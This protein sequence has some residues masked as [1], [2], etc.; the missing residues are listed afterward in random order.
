MDEVIE[1]VVRVDEV[2]SDDTVFIE[3]LDKHDGVLQRQRFTAL[4]LTLGTAYRSDFI[5]D[6]VDDAGASHV[7]LRLERAEDG[8]LELVAAEGSTKFWAPGGMTRRWRVDA[9]QAASI[10]GARL[11]IRTPAYAPATDAKRRA[12]MSHLNLGR[13]AWVWSL[14][15]VFAIFFALAWISDIDGGKVATYLSSGLGILMMIVIWASVWALVSRL[16]G[17]ASHFLTH[18]AV[19][20]LAFVALSV[21]DY[22]LDTAAFSFNMSSLQRYS[23]VLIGLT[24]GIAA[25]VHGRQIARVGRTTAAI[26]A[27]LIGAVLFVSQAVGYYTLRGNIASSQTLTELRP[28]ALRVAKGSTLDGFFGDAEVLKEKSEQSRPEKPEG[29]DFGVNDD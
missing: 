9:D 19:G 15:L 10:A 14:L 27:V 7:A 28:P 24:F 26:T 29:G 20:A 11:R 21:I 25:W 3:S 2:D 23:Y 13:F 8:A 18:L 16:T 22:V 17:R 1:H 4:P 6:A 5:V 12:S